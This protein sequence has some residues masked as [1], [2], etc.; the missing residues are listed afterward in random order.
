MMTELSLHVLDVANNSIR[1]NANLIEIKIIIHRK[2]DLLKIK[3]S[4]NGC[5]MDKEQLSKV[6][7]PFFTTRTTRGVGLGI[8]F[9]KQAAISCG[10]NFKIESLPKCGTK[11]VATFSLSHIDRMPLGDINSTIHTLITL[12]PTVDFI[13]YYEFDHRSFQLDTREFRDILGN[14]PL[15]TPEVSTYIKEYLKEKQREV[16]DGIQV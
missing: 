12:N 16:D 9:F 10:G 6:E 1:A 15:N 8:P 3:I 11:V 7:D 14:I 13:Y 2:A 5:G 4:D